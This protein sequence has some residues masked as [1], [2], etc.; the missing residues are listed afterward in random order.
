MT[1][2]QVIYDG[3][4][5]FN[6]IAVSQPFTFGLFLLFDTVDLPIDE[7]IEIGFVL[8][9]KVPVIGRTIEKDLV[10]PS[11]EFI[12]TLDSFK[13]IEIPREYSDAGYEMECGFHSAREISNFRAYV[14]KGA[15]TIEEIGRSVEELKR[16]FRTSNTSNTDA[17]ILTLGAEFKETTSDM[18]LLGGI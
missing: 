15:C 12:G 7:G 13:V 2:L 4:L 16:E 11:L 5:A 17:T 8:T 6:T 14:L 1:T 10:L 18:G 3:S 9:I